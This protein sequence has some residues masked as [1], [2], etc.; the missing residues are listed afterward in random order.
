[1]SV[2]VL[3]SNKDIGRVIGEGGKDISYIRETCKAVLHISE[4]VKGLRERILTIKGLE[5][6]VMAALEHVVPKLIHTDGD[7]S[8]ERAENELNVVLLVPNIMAGRII[9]KGGEKIKSIKQTSGCAVNVA[10]DALEGSTERKVTLTGS[11]EAIVA[12]LQPIVNVL[13]ENSNRIRD[14]QMVYYTPGAVSP[15]GGNS[16]L[17]PLLMN[18][19]HLAM[20]AAAAQGMSRGGAG[21]DGGRRVPKASSPMSPGHPAPIQVPQSVGMEQILTIQINVPATSIGAIIGH[22]GANIRDIRRQ[23]GADIG[24]AESMVGD[25]RSIMI[26]GNL[27]QN[28][29]ALYLIQST[30]AAAPASRQQQRDQRGPKTPAEK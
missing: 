6:Q 10:N 24:V 15:M 7:A 11:T 27:R 22:R 26:K 12:A 5:E 30:L 28:E 8:E 9:G 13:A 29:L 21:G 1:M 14:A 4:M 23:S 25:E 2:R 17:A 16:F 18:A 20:A 19:P 3:L